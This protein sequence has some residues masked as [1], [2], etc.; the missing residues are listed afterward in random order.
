MNVETIKGDA[1][2]SVTLSEEPDGKVRITINGNTLA[3]SIVDYKALVAAIDKVGGKT[4][5][6]PAVAKPKVEEPTQTQEP[7]K[8]NKRSTN[9]VFLNLQK[10]FELHPIV[11]TKFD[12]SSQELYVEQA[13]AWLSDKSNLST[14]TLESADWQEVYEHFKGLKE[15]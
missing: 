11:G 13:M 5:E 12:T 2:S 9:S 4:V 14:K 8:T 10:E 15:S 6:P 7:R 3:M 1:N